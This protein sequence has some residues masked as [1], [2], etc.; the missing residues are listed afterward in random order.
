MS[1]EKLIKVAKGELPADLVLKN[2]QI[3]NV[4]NGEIYPGDVCIYQDRIAA[5][6][7]PNSYKGVEEIDCTCKYLAPGFIDGHIHL[8]SSMVTV[9]EFARAVVP[10]GTTA[11]VAD[12][13]EIANV[14]GAEGILYMLKSSK[15]N[16]LSTYI[17]L[18]SCVPA[19]QLETAGAELKAIDL[20]PFLNDK[21]V[22]GLGEVM[23]FPGVLNLEEELLN[24]IKLTKSIGNKVVEGHA[25]KLSQAELCA[26][27]AA[28]IQSDHECTTLEEAKEKLSLGMYIMIREGTLTK[29]L[30]DLLPIVTP[31]TLDRCMFVTDDCDPFY[32]VEYGHIDHVIR[33]A[34]SEG[35][36]PVSAIRMVTINPAKYFRLENLGAIIPGYIAD[37]VIL[38]DLNTCKVECV[39]KHGKIVAKNGRLVFPE[40]SR[41]SITLRGSIN[42][43]WLEL[44]DFRIE[45][46]ANNAKCRIIELVPHQIITRTLIE[47]PKTKDNEV[48]ADTESDILKLVVIERHSAS[49]NIGKALVKGF[50]L[51]R[52]ALASSVAHDSHNIIIVGTND[53]DML[54]AAVQIIKMQGGLTAVCDGKVLEALPLPIAGL[55]SDRPLNEVKE[56]LASLHEKA[57]IL[58]A[59]VEEPFMHLSFL[60]LPVI[61]E[62]K[63]TD[64][65]LIDVTSNKIVNLWVD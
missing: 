33:K 19:T 40:P 8:E 42:V 65:G 35:L 11:V 61:P 46:R 29:N 64:R 62:L 41:P 14:L 37:L 56:K 20:Y 57:R 10:R 7:K 45:K 48:I 6:G 5:V 2:V 13:H 34:V 53:S 18:P 16:P 17:T 28:G 49:G 4:L 38:E 25:P 50:G 43:K 55:I 44:N 36:D 15:Y 27:I 31:Y 52:G 22:L 1:L 39:I 26:Y 24:K 63:L 12:P 54:T 32:L 47:K 21:W 30:S 51:K 59:T 3:V 60:A 58:G 9:S 23:N